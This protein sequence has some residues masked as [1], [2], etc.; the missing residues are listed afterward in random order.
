MGNKILRIRSVDHDIFNAIAD[1]SKVIETRAA[2]SKYREVKVGEIL[3]F[4]CGKERLSKEVRSVEIFRTIGALLKKYRPETINPKFHSEKE[5]RKMWQR[6]P[7]YAEKIK[8]FGLVAWE[9]K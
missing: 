5:V 1:G 9:L 3:T 2:T 4:I 8:K 7:G 6:F